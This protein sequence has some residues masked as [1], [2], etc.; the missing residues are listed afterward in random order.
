MKTLKILGVVACLFGLFF[1][2]GVQADERTKGNSNLGTKITD[3]AGCGKINKI[4]YLSACKQCVQ[5]AGKVWELGSG[6][7]TAATLPFTVEVLDMQTKV[8]DAAT[9]GQ[10]PVKGKIPDCKKCVAAGNVWQ[11]GKGCVKS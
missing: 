1:G 3:I 4:E 7:Q 9:C 11:T 5:S 10:I 2:Q 6:C 8:K